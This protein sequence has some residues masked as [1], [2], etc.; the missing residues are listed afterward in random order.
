MTFGLRVQVFQLLRSSRRADALS[1]A[2][3]LLQRLGRAEPHHHVARFGKVFE[4][5]VTRAEPAVIAR[6]KHHEVAGMPVLHR[7]NVD[8]VNLATERMDRLHGDFIHARLRRQPGTETAG[9]DG[10]ARSS[11]LSSRAHA[12]EHAPPEPG[13]A[14]A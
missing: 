13:L 8:G 4:Y 5:S 2:C 12:G 6:G 7:A 3:D 1:G 11:E 10:Q 9:Q 14:T